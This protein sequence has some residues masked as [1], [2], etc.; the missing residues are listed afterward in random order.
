MVALAVLLA[1]SAT[2]SAGIYN[3]RERMETPQLTADG[4]KPLPFKLFR[5]ARSV[6][7]QI[8][9]ERLKPNNNREKYLQAAGRLRTKLRP[10]TITPDECV[11]LSEYLIRLRLYD[12]AV[13]VLN[14]AA[15]EDRRNFMVS[16]NLA[17][18][19]QLAGRLDQAIRYLQQV[20]DN[21]RGEWLA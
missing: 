2:A 15:A 3:P 13:E 10:R 9:N 7:S 18:A 16:A 1:T 19:H 8:G 14:P 17:A 11:S 12:E 6:F 4:A 5:D 20:K 21:W